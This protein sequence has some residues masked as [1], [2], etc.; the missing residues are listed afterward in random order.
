MPDFKSNIWKVYA[1]CFL[2]NVMFISAVLI[3]FF[4]DWGRLS[5][6]QIMLLQAWFMAWSII[7][8]VPT[9]AFADRFGRRLSLVIASLLGVSWVIVY[10]SA[11][12]F[13]VFMA[14]EFLAAVATALTSGSLE[15]LTYDSLRQSGT[16]RESKRVFIRASQFVMAGI[17]FGSVTG[18]IVASRFGLDKA[19][20]LT[21][22][23]F[24]FG[25]FVA[26]S[27]KEPRHLMKKQDY[28]KTLVAGFL[29]MF[30]HKAVKLLAMDFSVISAIAFAMIW[31]YQVLLKN[32]GVDVAFFG[33]VSAGSVIGQMAFL[34]ATPWLESLLGSR[35]LLLFLSA[36]LTGVMFIVAAI[37]LNPF[38]IAAAAIIA[39]SLGLGRG[40]LFFSYMNKFIPSPKRA[41][42]LSSV[43]L[44]SKAIK[45]SVYLFLSV[46]FVWSVTYSLIILG[47]AAI[48]FSLVSGVEEAH[49]AD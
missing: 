7:L 31:V 6:A 29:F 41:T 46:L 11:P 38:L 28:R 35:K 1:F 2:L 24:A 9:G 18:G 27:M 15:A 17:L 40:T 23:P 33:L 8:E 30:R 21:A 43:G 34:Q 36:M 47:A 45:L 10:S 42:V 49:L 16:A 14:G 20:L 19:L 32:A 4:S 5:F 12:N 22:V 39:I 25:F 26:L 13:Y 44:L 3:P 48:I 37:A